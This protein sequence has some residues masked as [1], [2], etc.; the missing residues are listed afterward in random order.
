MLECEVCPGAFI[1]CK[2]NAL[3][4]VG[5][6]Y[7]LDYSFHVISRSA[8]MFTALVVDTLS[9]IGFTSKRLFLSPR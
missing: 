2:L 9:Q 8:V 3:L 4:C 7:L 1:L 6:I 5:S